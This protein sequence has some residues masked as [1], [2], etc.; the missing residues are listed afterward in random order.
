MGAIAC[1]EGL[2]KIMKQ[3]RTG[4]IGV[5]VKG[6]K[7]LEQL[8]RNHHFSIEAIAD[9]NKDLA[10]GTAQKYDATPYDDSRQLIVQENLDVLF[11]L[12]PTYLCGE[13][14]QLAAK[15]G[16]HVFKDSP[17]ARTLPEASQWV[18]QMEKANLQFHVSAPWRFSPGYLHAYHKIIDN[19]IGKVFLIR[20]ESFKRYVGDFGWR[21]DPVLAGG[22]VLIEM[23]Y[24]LID[25]IAW[26]MGPP[27]QL[28]SLT[29]GECRKQ[30]LPPYRTED[31]AA[32]TMNFSNG[33]MGNLLCGWM[34]GPSSEKMFFYG[35]DGTLE[36][37]R[38]SLTRYCSEG[39]VRS[40]ESFEVNESWMVEQQLRNFVD[41]LIDREIKPV[42]TA[43]EHL[44]NVA[45]VESAYLSA[46]TRLPE[47]LKV[48]GKVFQIE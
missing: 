22:G 43:R 47:S 37:T 1:H 19:Q 9:Q 28:Y 39:K 26:N 15:T 12:L 8:A 36:V 2:K 29:T 38:T 5:G 48:Y 16:T 42:S 27:E 31:T 32:V 10:H 18:E 20:A 46:R 41:C 11:L 14:I 24:H 30:T 21:G 13:Y 6:V 45:I 17:L 25:Q 34:S 44:V 3:L 40:S 35:T 4:I 23:G 7:L 33:A